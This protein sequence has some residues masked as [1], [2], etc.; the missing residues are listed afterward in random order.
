[1]WII[2][3]YLGNFCAGKLKIPLFSTFKYCSVYNVLI[4]KID[5]NDDNNDNNEKDINEKIF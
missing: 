1:M 5:N 3:T 4:K 2:F